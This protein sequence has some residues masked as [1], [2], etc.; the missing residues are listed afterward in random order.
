MP[1]RIRRMAP[2]DREEFAR[3]FSQAR[4]SLASATQ[5]LGRP[6]FGHALLRLAPLRGLNRGRAEAQ[7]TLWWLEG[8]SER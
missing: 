1:L 3:G 2:L 6:A 8:A 7:G 5:D 4:R